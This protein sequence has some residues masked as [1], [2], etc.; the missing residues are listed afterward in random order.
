MAAAAEFTNVSKVYDV[1]PLRRRGVAAVCEVSL[2]VE[3]GEVLGLLG[4]NRAGKTTLVKV[5]LSLCRPS[6]GQVQRLGQ[7]LT[8]R[9]TLARVGYV[10][11]NH[12]FPRYLMLP[13]CSNTT[14]PCR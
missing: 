6:G 8:D 11:E 4:P 10:H 13:P 5:L 7:P 3:G 9:S 2:R 1:G 12:A 14:V